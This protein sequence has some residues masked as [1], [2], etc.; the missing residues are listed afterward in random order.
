MN[1][2]HEKRVALAAVGKA[3][4][5]LL[6]HRAKKLKIT[7][8][9]HRDFVTNA[10]FASEKAIV[11]TLL[12][13]FPDH[14]VYA[15]ESGLTVGAEPGLRS[16]RRSPAGLRRM[17]RIRIKNPPADRL[18]D[19]EWLWVVDPLDGT[20]NFAHGLDHFN[21]SIALH[22]KGQRVLGIVRS[23]VLDET[24]IALRGRGATRNGKRLR[25]KERPL[26]GALFLSY[27]SAHYNYAETRRAL[28]MVGALLTR[29]HGWRD[30]GNGA[31]DLAQVAR[32][33][34]DFLVTMKCDAFSFSAAAL[35]VE[36]AGGK[37]VDF[38]GAPWDVTSKDLIAGPPNLVDEVRGVVN[39]ALR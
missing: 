7:G 12:G 20:I 21:V 11:E 34:V 1:L 17:G 33:T 8:K 3:E 38:S 14:A 4:R 2:D 27:V 18:L 39:A 30:F 28:V 5:I 37:V 15:E 26:R 29:C 31:A 23:P 22:H 25:V 13:A 24:T 36:E 32:G 35:A 16:E 19:Q 6:H 10:D 9:L